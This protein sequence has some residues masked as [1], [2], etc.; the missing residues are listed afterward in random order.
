MYEIIANYMGEMRHTYLT[1]VTRY[2]N[3]WQEQ[4]LALIMEPRVTQV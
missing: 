2:M 4:I 3:I 1:V